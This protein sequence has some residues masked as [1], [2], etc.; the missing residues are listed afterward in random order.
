MITAIAFTASL[1]VVVLT[2]LLWRE[3]S[4]RV[5]WRHTLDAITNTREQ[6]E[7]LR[8]LQ[9]ALVDNVRDKVQIVTTAAIEL[10]TTLADCR[11]V[12]DSMTALIAS[13]GYE[14]VRE[15]G[16]RFMDDVIRNVTT[17]LTAQLKQG[18]VSR[19]TQLA[20]EYVLLQTLDDL[21]L[22]VRLQA[23]NY[24]PEAIRATLIKLLEWH[25]RKPKTVT[26]DRSLAEQF[27]Q[28]TRDA[29]DLAW[30]L[31]SLGEELAMLE[32]NGAI[33]VA[34]K[35]QKQHV[36]DKLKDTEK[37]NVPVAERRREAV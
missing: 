30:L 3:I 19:T 34:K 28:Q 22:E 33:A 21:D 11:A 6:V 7:T 29:Q 14:W 20:G 18:L 4:D 26:D 23:R 12:R 10:Q 13:N 5:A 17:Q 15:Y 1:L 36:T 8:S 9:T 35:Q 16:P 2:Y 31:G 27:K 32:W 24:R 25:P 37:V